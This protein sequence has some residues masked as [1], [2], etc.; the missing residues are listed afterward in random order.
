MIPSEEFWE[1]W[2]SGILGT[3]YA[4]FPNAIE[5]IL[6]PEFRNSLTA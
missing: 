1:F 4:I 3:V 5:C 6:S 2:N